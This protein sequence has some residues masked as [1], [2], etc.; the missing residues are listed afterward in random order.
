MSEEAEVQPRPF[1]LGLIGLG[2]MGVP[3]A[4]RLLGQGWRLTVWN[5][6]PE[7]FEDVRE[8][9]A[10]WADSP[11]AV[12]AACDIV[13]ICVL[14]ED[15]V[16]DICFGERGLAAAKGAH[17]VIDLSTTAVETTRRAAAELDVAWLDSPISGGPAAAESGEL[18]L[19]VG[20]AEE[21]YDW[22]KAVLLDLG[23]N[24][25]LMGP[26]GAGQ[27]TKVINQAIVGTNYVLMGE[28]LAQV[29]AAG[30]DGTKLHECLKG[31]LAD[32][33]ILQR[34]FPQI[35]A[36]DFD[37]PR[38]RARQLDKDLHAVRAFNEGLGLSLP[39]QDVAI[40]QYRHYV[41]DGNGEMDSASVCR[42]YVPDKT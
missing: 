12:R 36:G 19:M 15:A 21:L 13:L 34:I 2:I 14:G 4:R 26:L 7:R 38:G 37:P 6:E 27:T 39:V 3:I 24:V 33:E 41:E 23:A 35:Y 1:R 29:R 8:A 25:T 28:I 22:V 16:E 20:G 9:G 17:I 40:D 18:T 42:I 5:R 30:I 10:V 31:G 32:S 11:A